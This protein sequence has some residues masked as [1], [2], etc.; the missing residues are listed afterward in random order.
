MLREH[1]AE[2][3]RRSGRNQPSA[4]VEPRER[5]G[6]VRLHTSELHQGTRFT[7]GPKPATRMRSCGGVAERSN[8]P[9]LKTGVGATPPWVRIPPPPPRATAFHAGSSFSERIP[10][11]SRR[12]VSHSANMRIV[13]AAEAARTGGAFE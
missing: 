10:S 2:E 1:N 11:N 7:A 5:F 8:V 12:Q 3:R 4:E 9:V 6:V 13:L